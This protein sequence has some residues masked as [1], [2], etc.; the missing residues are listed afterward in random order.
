MSSIYRTPV[1]DICDHCGKIFY[2]EKGL[3]QE[4][5][6]SCIKIIMKHEQIKQNR[7]EHNKLL[8]ASIFYSALAQL[9]QRG[10]DLYEMA[11]AEN[12]P[13]ELNKIAIM[14]LDNNINEIE[15]LVKSMGIADEHRTE[16]IRAVAKKLKADI[17]EEELTQIISE[18]ENI[19][20][21]LLSD[22]YNERKNEKIEKKLDYSSEE[23]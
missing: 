22:D 17:N 4:T 10:M 20:D 5:C 18:E 9:V 21:E 3:S 16:Y 12:T 23:Y 14:Q 15:F 1:K 19:I 11:K 8:R 13:V 7:E 2:P 6:D